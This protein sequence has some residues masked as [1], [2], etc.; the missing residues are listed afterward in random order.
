VAAHRVG[1]AGEG[2]GV[3]LDAPGDADDGAVG[4]ELAQRLLQQLARGP[5]AQAP[6]EVDRHVV[7]GP[8]RAAQRVGPRR[9]QAG[10]LH[11]VHAGL[12]DDDG[13]ALD[14][15]AAAPGP[16]GELRVLPRGEVGVAL[17]VVLDQPL[18]HDG[19]GGH[20]D[21]Q[22]EGLGGEHRADEPADEQL[23]DG[24]LE[25][26]Q[27]AGVVRGDAP[28]QRL[29]PL[30]VAQHRQVGLGQLRGVLLDDAADL[31]QPRPRRSAAARS[32]RTARRR[33]R[34]RPG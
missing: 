24:L 7:A 1:V 9:R 23:L 8:E 27:H 18:Q 14:V 11:G 16:P 13:V 22:R 19:A 3:A 25:R 20:V 30:P 12:P 21:A 34:S 15:D 33:R 2:L 17:A 31:L 10:D 4:L 6:D 29:A 32:A 26:G 5:G 28:L